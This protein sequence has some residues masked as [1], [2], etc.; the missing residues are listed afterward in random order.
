MSDEMPSYLN[1]LAETFAGEGPL[2]STELAAEIEATVPEANREARAREFHELL[3]EKM[4]ARDVKF[5]GIYALVSDQAVKRLQLIIDE[6]VKVLEEVATPKDI[7][8]LYTSGWTF[9]M[10]AWGKVLNVASNLDLE[11]TP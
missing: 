4:N 6:L 7:R 10:I 1:R 9:E 8:M 11:V 3:R 2:D 5:V